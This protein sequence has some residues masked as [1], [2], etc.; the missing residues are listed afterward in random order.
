ME[1]QPRHRPQ[2]QFPGAKRLI[3]ECELDKCIHCGS[4]LVNRRTWYVKKHVQTLAGPVFVAGKSKKCVNP[5]C[6]HT[7]ETYY[8]SG[9][10]TISLP[11]ST[12]G[13]DVL[14]FIGWQ[15]EQ[16]HQQLVEIQQKLNQRGVLINERSV[17]KLYRQ[18]LALL[19]GMTERKR[20]RLRQAEQDH[21][22]IIWALDALQ[23]EGHESLLYVLYEVWSQTPVSA[24]QLSNPTAARLGEWLKPYTQL[25]FTVLATLSDGEKGVMAAMK[26]SWPQAPHQHCQLHFLNGVAEPAMEVDAQLRRQ[27]RDDLGGL[28]AV[29]EYD[30]TP[31]FCL[32]SE[33]RS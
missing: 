20:E 7:G 25:P 18:F 12:Y 1:K 24:L 31:P 32:T 33:M 16:E 15:H 27:L 6:P 2:R 19:G 22:G 3:I 13:L 28:E 5:D 14:A 9:V 8:A 17:G 21:G 4:A 11:Y 23:P 30:D 10:L 29:P 26:E